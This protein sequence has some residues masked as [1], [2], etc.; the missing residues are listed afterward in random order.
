MP[1]VQDDATRTVAE[2][3][4]A[5]K[6]V[7]SPVVATDENGDTLTY[8]LT[9][10]DG[11]TDGDAALF[12]IDW[13]TGQIMTKGP[14]DHEAKSP[15]ETT[16]TVVVRATDPT[17]I[18]G[19]NPAVPANS[20]TVTVII[21]VTDVNEAP[22]VA[23][24]AAATFDE[25]TG[26][27]AATLDA[28]TATDPDDGAPTPT[29]SVDGAD[30]SKFTAVGGEL[31]FKT[32]PDYENPTDANKDNVYE[33]TVQASDGKK[34]GMKKVMVS[35]LNADEEGVV[36]LSKVQPVVGIPVKAT[37]TDPDGGISKLT[38]QWST[39]GGANVIDDAISD[40]YTPVGGDVGQTLTATAS[41]FD[42]QSATTE[43][44]ADAEATNEVERDT[45]NKRPVFGDEDLDTE[46]V[47]NATATRKVEENTAADASDDSTTDAP[48]DNVGGPVVATDSK[49][50]GED[51][52]TL[53]YSLGGADA[54]MFRVRDNGQIEVAAGTMLDYETK[55]TYRVT[56]M[57]EDP[58][59]ASASIMVTIMVTDLDEMPDVS[60]DEKVELRR[61]RHWPGS[62]VQGEGPGGGIHP[63]VSGWCRRRR[64]HDRERR[65]SL[66]GAPRLR[67]PQGRHG[68]HFQHLHRGR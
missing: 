39:N 31:R 47:Q 9:N 32:K 11:S 38:W 6:T 15:A 1:G 34:T 12:S 51:A 46:G 50:A 40:T 52:E 17:G 2:N 57:A 56:V 68:G 58:L 43:K 20:G 19:A 36:T 59:G 55:K 35:V 63:V 10:A 8:T 33:V 18:P 29:W 44:D 49:A 13:G 67:E 41:Y 16:Y 22:V 25:S 27:I 53:T 37:L 62:D 4:S 42:G 61:E 23:G 30:G 60:G 5:G 48:G 24:D 14:L 45:R 64:L 3:T 26:A 28:Y 66:Q 7:G 54:A 21:T 65:A